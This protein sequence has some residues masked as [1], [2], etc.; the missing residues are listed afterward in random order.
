MGIQTGLH[1]QGPLVF[2]VIKLTVSLFFTPAHT[3]LWPQNGHPGTYKGIGIDK[4]NSP[5]KKYKSVN[6]GYPT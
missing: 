3:Y 2:L 6:L 5:L 4:I 1:F